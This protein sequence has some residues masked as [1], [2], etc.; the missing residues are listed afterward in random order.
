[1]T[2]TVASG[3]SYLEDY[4]SSKEEKPQDRPWEKL[5]TN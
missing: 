3:T 2:Q 1:M 4:G 5:H